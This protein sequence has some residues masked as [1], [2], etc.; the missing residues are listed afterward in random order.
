[1]DLSDEEVIILY[2]L[3]RNMQLLDVSVSD[4][5]GCDPGNKTL[6]DLL[7][8]VKRHIESE[9]SEWMRGKGIEWWW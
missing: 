7:H 2:N 3:F 5:V 8:K 6:I 9:G 4:Y 1:M